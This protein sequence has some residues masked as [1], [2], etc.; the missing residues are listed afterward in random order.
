[1]QPSRRVVTV[2]LQVFRERAQNC[3][4]DA[5]NLLRER[6]V[7]GKWDERG[8]THSSPDSLMFLAI[9]LC[10]SLPLFV[11]FPSFG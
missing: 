7:N 10:P 4:L 11:I 8:N 9:P 2:A 5:Q 3:I 6:K 1:M